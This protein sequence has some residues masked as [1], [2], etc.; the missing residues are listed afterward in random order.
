[1]KIFRPVHIKDCEKLA[2]QDAEGAE[3]AVERVVE[4]LKSKKII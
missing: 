3:R 1:V 2:A 4:L